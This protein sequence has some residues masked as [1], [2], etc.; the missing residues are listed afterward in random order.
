MAILGEAGYIVSERYDSIP[1]AVLAVL[2]GG[3][4]ISS[5][6]RANSERLSAFDRWY[7]IIVDCKESPQPQ[8]SAH[9]FE[10][11]I[12]PAF[13]NDS[14]SMGYTVGCVN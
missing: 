2:C 10:R 8:S 9:G 7:R 12:I 1:R 4:D 6:S 14:M 3:A 13:S 11:R 5:E